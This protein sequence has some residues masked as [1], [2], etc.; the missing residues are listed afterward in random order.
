MERG[1]YKK[2]TGRRKTTRKNCL[3]ISVTESDNT[4]NRQDDLCNQSRTYEGTEEGAQSGTNDTDTLLLEVVQILTDGDTGIG[5]D[6]CTDRKESYL[7]EARSS[8]AF[9]HA[10]SQASWYRAC[11]KAEDDRDH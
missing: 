1:F 3:V 6:R 2:K 7:V 8:S 10:R 5:Q 9:R 4:G 11:R